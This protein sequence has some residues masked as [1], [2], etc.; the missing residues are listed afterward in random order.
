MMKLAETEGAVYFM[1]I[2]A[3]ILKMYHY[4]TQQSSTIPQGNYLC[5]VSLDICT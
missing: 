1:V 5:H 4:F 2:V 3:K